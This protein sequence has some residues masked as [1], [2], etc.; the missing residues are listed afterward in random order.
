MLESVYRQRNP[1]NSPYYQCVEGH[2]ETFEQVYKDRFERRYGFFRPC[3][4]QV[5][6]SLA[7]C[8][9]DDSTSEPTAT[10]FLHTAAADNIVAH[11]TVISHPELDGNPDA[12][13]LVTQNWNPGGIGGTYN[14][15][16]IGVWY[17][18][19]HWAIFNQGGGN[20]IAVGAAFNVRVITGLSSAATHLT[21]PTGNLSHYTLIEHPDLDGNPDALF[22]TTQS[23]KNNCCHITDPVIVGYDA[24]IN[25]AWAIVNQNLEQ[26]P[27][28]ATFNLQILSGENDFVH[29]ADA[30]NISGNWTFISHPE[31]DGNPDA[32]FQVTQNLNPGGG[33]EVLNPNFIGVWYDGDNWAIFNQDTTVDIPDGASFNVSVD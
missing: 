5:M 6:L 32:T 10:A 9:G 2:F 31:L 27:A 3:V 21:V 7:A 25:Q 8:G 28:G 1:Q 12:I 33:P 22:L 13:L 18:D 16:G 15:H 29:T 19:D 4:G 23:W 20:P 17:T 24:I 30:G 11:W 26:L 14:N